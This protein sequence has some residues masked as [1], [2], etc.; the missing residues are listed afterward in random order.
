MNCRCCAIGKG[1]GRREIAVGDLASAGQI[2]EIVMV[3]FDTK[4]EGLPL[5]VEPPRDQEWRGKIGKPG[6]DGECGRPGASF[7]REKA[8][9]ARMFLAISPVKQV[10]KMV[11]MTKVFGVHRR[12]CKPSGLP[13]VAAEKD[14]EQARR[15]RARGAPSPLLQQRP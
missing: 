14:A 12:F 10:M 2:A 1:V 11:F 5:S 4:D 13:A 8:S 6:G 15:G 9:V 7:R 3:T